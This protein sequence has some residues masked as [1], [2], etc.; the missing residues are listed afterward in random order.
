MSSKKKKR[1]SSCLF[2]FEESVKTAK[3]FEKD[4]DEVLA[5]SNKR[6]YSGSYYD[7]EKLLALQDT[8]IL[9]FMRTFLP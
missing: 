6:L 3:A 7:Q 4:L 1:K 9:Y 8:S 5:A 2:G